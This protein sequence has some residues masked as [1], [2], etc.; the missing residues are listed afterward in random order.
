MDL[1]FDEGP[2]IDAGLF[3]CGAR[4]TWEDRPFHPHRDRVNADISIIYVDI[5]Q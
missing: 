4:M 5:R 1:V 3:G 2:P